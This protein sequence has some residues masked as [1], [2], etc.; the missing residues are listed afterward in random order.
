L[1]AIIPW[2]PERRNFPITYR[3]PLL[4]VGFVL[5]Q[6]E[7]LS[8]EAIFEAPI[9]LLGSAFPLDKILAIATGSRP[10]GAE[11]GLPGKL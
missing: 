3:K 10:F 11:L 8:P 4:F 7:K 5:S 1:G 6:E 2:L 9:F